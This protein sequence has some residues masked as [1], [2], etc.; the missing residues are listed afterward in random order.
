[1]TILGQHTVHELD[2]LVKALGFEV[3]QFQAAGVACRSWMQRD[4]Q[5]YAAWN[6]QLVLAMAGWS[7]AVGIA[8][9]RID[10]TPQALWDAV[11]AEAHFQGCLDAFHPF[12]D[13][14]RTFL[15]QS[16]CT[17]S[18]D[19]TPQP[20]A[21]DFDLRQYQAADR[22]TRW[23]EKQAGAVEVKAKSYAPVIIVGLGVV[24][25]TIALT[26]RS[27]ISAVLP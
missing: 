16:E 14:T 11:P 17:I 15:Q 12:E 10:E 4:P 21:P 23:I 2:D 27:R 22:A 3:Q 13:L 1:M 25:V 24:V 26:V 5:A 18:F 6:T 19:G 8:K 9:T 20:T 7:T